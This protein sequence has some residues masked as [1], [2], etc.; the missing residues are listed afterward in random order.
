MK[1]RIQILGFPVDLDD[2]RMVER[3]IA[4][5]L[6]EPAGGLRH[7]VTVNPEYQ[8]AA[9]RSRKFA[10]VLRSAELSLAD[11]VGIQAA[12]R[13]L[14]LPVPPRIT[15]NDLVELVA[16][17]PHPAKRIFLLGAAP[18]VAGEAAAV[19]HARH[20]D[21]CIVGTFPGEPSPEGWEEIS[22]AL[23][24]CRPTVLFVA[25]G[26][27]RQDLWIATYR[28]RLAEH[29]IL[30]ASGIGGVYDYLSGRV[31]RAPA[32]LRRLGLEWLYRLIRQP[33]R[34]RRQAALPRF[35]VLVLAESVTSLFGRSR[36]R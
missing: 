21:A 2:S 6:D 27:P 19:L 24:A 3:R 29:G 33:W 30:V 12:A 13:L 4:G 23:A 9:C 36:A 7:V 20:P 25:F 15:G 5:W 8:I 10:H 16:G 34:W 31:P 28:E 11:G 14:R 35:V 18:G 32:P 26:H 22:A 1:G 17:L